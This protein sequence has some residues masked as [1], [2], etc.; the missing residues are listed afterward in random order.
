M[1]RES[2]GWHSMLAS[3]RHGM[4]LRG[5]EQTQSEECLEEEAERTWTRFRGHPEC[6]SN[7]P[8]HQRQLS[9]QTT[10]DC[11]CSHCVNF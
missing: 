2:P 1:L 8:V 10:I 7:S 5:A 3:G 6:P 11:N 4:S 9:K